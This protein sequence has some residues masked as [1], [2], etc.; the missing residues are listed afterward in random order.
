MNNAHNATIWQLVQLQYHV[1][2]TKTLIFTYGQI[3]MCNKA[4]E[5]TELTNPLSIIANCALPHS[6]VEPYTPSKVLVFGI[7]SHILN[8]SVHFHCLL[9]AHRHFQPL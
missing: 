9:R 2:L 7:P 8:A 6:S 4:R 5:H 1:A 3:L